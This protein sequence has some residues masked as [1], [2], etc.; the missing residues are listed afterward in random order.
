MSDV[1]PYLE[2]RTAGPSGFSPDGSRI[3]ISSNLSGT[4]QLYR[5]PRD[6]GDLVP[7]TALDEPVGGSYLPTE[8]RLL[9]AADVGGNERY[10]LYVM[11]DDPAEPITAAEQLDELVVDPDH[12]HRPGGVSRDGSQLAFA[13]NRR[14]GVDFDVYVK[15]LPDGEERSVFAPGGWCGGAGFRPDGGLLAVHRLT[16]RS[17]DNEVHLVDLASGD[18][19]ELAPHPDEEASVGSPSWRPDG[20]SFLFST[21]IDREFS[22]VARGTADGTW[23]YV[24]EPGWDAGAAYDWTGERLLV[25]A[26]VDGYSRAALHDPETLDELAPI[27]LPGDGVAGGF[28]FSRDGR[29]LTFSFSSALVPGDAWIQDLDTGEQRRLTTSP[30]DVDTDTFVAPTLERF[31]SHDGVEVPVYVYRPPRS[32]G[33]VPVVAYL[34]GGPESQFRPTFSPLIQ[35]LVAH[36]F[37]VIAPN[38]RGSTGYGRTYEHLDDGRK[39]LDAVADLAAMHDWVASTD[40]LDPDRVALYGGSYGGYLVLAGLTM[41]PDRWAAGVDVVGISSLV[42]FLENTAPWR[43]K[44]REREYGSLEHDRDFLLEASPMSHIDAIRAPLFIVHGANDPR[45]PLGEA[46]QIHAIVEGKGLRTEL[47][48]YEDEGHG[49]AK[50]RNRLDAYPRVVSF[51]EDVLRPA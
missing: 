9:I 30:C 13:S 43:R 11:G 16:E 36:G 19:V 21:N 29:Y 27:E 18:A 41:Q 34:H 8:D 17:G 22:G 23:E 4:S 28:R 50:L 15:A 42:T 26:N 47:L 31:A 6:G 44:F 39:R 45:V 32:T 12:I 37:A 49:L 25:A 38:I 48:V 33:R 2:I 46:E 24:L 51:L 14:D 3:V 10:Q 7:L 40:D 35:Y 1:R 5:I 20:A